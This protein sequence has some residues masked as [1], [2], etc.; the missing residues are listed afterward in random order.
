MSLKEK[1]LSLKS[2]GHTF[3]QIAKAI[4]KSQSQISA[5]LKDGYGGDSDALETALLAYYNNVVERKSS[6]VG[7]QSS[8]FLDIAN[9]RRAFAVCK[10]AHLDHEFAILASDSGLGKTTAL[11]EYASKNPGTI[12]ITANP[13]FNPRH[14]V[15]RIHKALGRSGQGLH[16][17]LMD[18]CID[19]LRGADR[20]II[21]D[22]ADQ[23]N[24]TCIEILRAFHDEGGVG[25]LV[26]GLPKLIE[27][28]RG[29]RGK[30]PQL[31]TRNGASYRL[32]PLDMQDTATIVRSMIGDADDSV[33]KAVHG[34]SRG[35]ARTVV[36][37]MKA[38][39]RIAQRNDRSVD[40]RL[41]KAATETLEV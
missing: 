3:A 35:I 25:I 34:A 26:A 17:D 29:V 6:S 22:E 1:I 30:H 15:R 39:M 16:A 41:V 20:L 13:T 10:I 2:D 18:D 19:L 27:I 32:T 33:V 36:K 12:V 4:G 40:A 37:I 21:I 8:S 11:R 9:A 7:G 24:A 28:I 31:Y 23:L 14:L 38:A 5:W